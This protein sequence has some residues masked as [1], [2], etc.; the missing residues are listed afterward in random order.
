LAKL[1]GLDVVTILEACSK[2]G[3]SMFKYGQLEITFNGW[4]TFASKSQVQLTPEGG[5][6]EVPTVEPVKEDPTLDELFLED[7]SAY[8]DALLRANDR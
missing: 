2:H 3:V 5:A 8:E 7:P 1:S 6:P 4:P